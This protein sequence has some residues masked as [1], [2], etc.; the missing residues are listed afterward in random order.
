V[1]VGATPPPVK[2]K[3]EK[4]ARLDNKP[5]TYTP[6]PVTAAEAAGTAPATPG[7]AAAGSAMASSATPAVPATAGTAARPSTSTA[8][9]STASTKALKVS[10]TRKRRKIKREKIRYGQAP[11]NSLPAGTEETVSAGADQ[12]A[13]ATSSIL[14]T[15]GS[16]ISALGET[17]SVDQDP[18]A[19]KPTTEGKT[20]FSDRA[21]VEKVKVKAAKA[22]QK[23]ELTPSPLTAE[24]KATK[25]VQSAPLEPGADGKKKKKKDKNAPKAR[26]QDQAPAPPAP[27]PDAT[28]IPPKSVRDNGEP[29]VT[30]VNPS[31]LPPVTAPAP[32]AAVDTTP[33]TPAN[34]APVPPQ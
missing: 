1:F 32:G 30:P 9:T 3:H 34:P 14:P 17:A 15:P 26:L 24:E 25:Q 21:P 20:R 12:G 18:L 27:K 11:R 7:A 2:R 28:P 33:S 29:E 23:A 4:K 13:G 6:T 31:T 16:G 5:T 22:E 10:A 19:A 8:S